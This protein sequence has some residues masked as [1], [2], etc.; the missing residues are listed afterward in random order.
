MTCAACAEVL[1]VPVMFVAWAGGD[2]IE[3]CKIQ[4]LPHSA[5]VRTSVATWD[6]IHDAR[7]LEAGS[8]TKITFGAILATGDLIKQ[9]ENWNYWHRP[10]CMNS[11]TAWPTVMHDLFCRWGRWFS[12]HWF[13]HWALSSW[14]QS[15]LGLNFSGLQATLRWKLLCFVPER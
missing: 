15:L 6:F 3:T 2:E 4:N 14:W 1:M 12:F 11:W 7:T 5:C 13:G 9:N 8:G 10:A